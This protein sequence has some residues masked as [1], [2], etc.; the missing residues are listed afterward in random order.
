MHRKWP[1]STYRPHQHLAGA[2]LARPRGN[3][4]TRDTRAP[5]TAPIST[6]LAQDWRGHEA[7]SPHETRIVDLLP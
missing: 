4:P 7:T 6:W 1:S 3:F 2:G 5:P